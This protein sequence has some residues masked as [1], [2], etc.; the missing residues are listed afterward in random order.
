MDPGNVRAALR[1]L[2][3]Q[4]V[5]ISVQSLDAWAQMHAVEEHYVTTQRMRPVREREFRA[6]RACARRVL[7]AIGY[8]DAPVLPAASRE[9]L[10]PRDV[11]G[12]ITHSRHL[13]AAAAG[14]SGALSALGIDLEEVAPGDDTLAA[15]TMTAGECDGRPAGVA[16]DVWRILHFSA[17]ESVF[18]ASFPRDRIFFEFHDIQLNFD[19]AGGTYHVGAGSCARARAGLG[20]LE[21]RWAICGRHIVTAAF[22]AL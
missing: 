5:A 17:K 22:A 21:G 1:E 16:S 11:I 9:P 6:G 3:P 10:W 20:K 12:S 15:M 14:R 7:C 19:V 8:H 18:K 13:A 4:S 2:L